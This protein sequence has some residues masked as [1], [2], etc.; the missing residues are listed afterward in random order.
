MAL[1]SPNRMVWTFFRSLRSVVARVPSIQDETEQRDQ[2]VLAMVLSVTAVEA[3]IN[4]YFRTLV[5]DTKYTQHRSMVIEGLTAKAAGG[6]PIGLKSKL[7][8]WP[9]KVLG[10][11]FAWQSGMAHDFDTL[12]LRRN[13][14]MH[15]SS[16]YEAI[17]VPGLRIEGV[18]NTACYDDLV[19]A[20]AIDALR[21]AQGMLEEVFRLAG[22]SEKTIPQHMHFW[23]G[24][25]R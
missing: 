14:L 1:S 18:A 8:D 3:F 21:L 10:K 22:E 6:K 5:E 11:S 15:F 16:S 7:D 25:P 17:Q 19:P 24:Q 23:T 13:A 9:P 20:D 4:L 2:I 12:R